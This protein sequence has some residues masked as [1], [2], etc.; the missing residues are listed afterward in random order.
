MKSYKNIGDTDITIQYTAN[1][2]TVTHIITSTDI[3]T[4]DETQTNGADIENQCISQNMQK[5]S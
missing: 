4:F 5:V 3:L 2:Q 1:G